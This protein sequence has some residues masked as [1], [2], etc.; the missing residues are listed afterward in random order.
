MLSIDEQWTLAIAWFRLLL[1]QVFL[2]ISLDSLSLGLF[3][4][5]TSFKVFRD[6]VVCYALKP[7]P[8]QSRFLPVFLLP[9]FF[10]LTAVLQGFQAFEV[11]LVILVLVLGNSW[12]LRNFN[13]IEKMF[14]DQRHRGGN[15]Y[16]PILV[17]YSF[18]FS[19]F[20]T[21]QAALFATFN[22]EA[23]SLRRNPFS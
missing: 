18:I 11:S 7:M 16:V 14:T 22:Y 13:Q 5:G 8:F 10:L 15:L 6:Q 21:S 2:F 4:V 1:K 23:T 3:L 12:T 9:F 17:I 19:L 20:L